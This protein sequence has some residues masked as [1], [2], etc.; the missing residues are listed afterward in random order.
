MSKKKS[1]LLAPEVCSPDLTQFLLGKEA[2]CVKKRRSD[3]FNLARTKGNQPYKKE[4]KG[5]IST[6]EVTMCSTSQ[7]DNQKK[8]QWSSQGE[9]ISADNNPHRMVYWLS[10]IGSDESDSEG[11][12]SPAI[13][14]QIQLSPLSIPPESKQLGT[15]DLPTRNIRPYGSKSDSGLTCWFALASPAPIG[16]PSNRLRAGASDLYI[17][18]NTLDNLKQAWLH[19]DYGWTS[20]TDRF[21]RNDGTT[22][23]PLNSCRVLEIRPSNGAPSWILRS[24]Q[25][26]YQLQGSRHKSALLPKLEVMTADVTTK[27]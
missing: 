8:Y 13:Y 12:I 20:I 27:S 18:Y 9:Y 4:K 23:H 11:N 6:I 16:A 3:Q 14:Q 2:R 15:P 22:V 26:S 1:N 17:H 21:E 7:S 25:A 24:T 10:P 19:Y 5:P